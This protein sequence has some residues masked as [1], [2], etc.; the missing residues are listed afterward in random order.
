MTTPSGQPESQSDT[1]PNDAEPTL[2]GDVPLPPVSSNTDDDAEP[3]D[4]KPLDPTVT[5]DEMPVDE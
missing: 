5:L 1:P 2:N 3:I 4:V